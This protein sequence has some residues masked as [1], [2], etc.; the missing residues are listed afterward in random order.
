MQDSTHS[1]Q[2]LRRAFL[3]NDEWLNASDEAGICYFPTKS[4]AKSAVDHLQVIPVRFLEY[5]RFQAYKLGQPVPLYYVSDTNRRVGLLRQAGQVVSALHL[6]PLHGP[7]KR[8]VL[9]VDNADFRV[10]LAQAPLEAELF[11]DSYYRTY[12]YFH[13]QEVYLLDSQVNRFRRFEEF[14]GGPEGVAELQQRF[15]KL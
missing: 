1:K 8:P 10:A 3:R 11:Y 15:R 6:V 7:G 13:Q 5:Q 9:F 14:V 12:A 4:E 2:V